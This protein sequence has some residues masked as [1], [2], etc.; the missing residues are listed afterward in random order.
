MRI[1]IG[2][3]AIALVLAGCTNTSPSN[4]SAIAKT[5]APMSGY[6]KVERKTLRD[7]RAVWDARKAAG[8]GDYVYTLSYSSV[9]GFGYT[10]EIEVS[11]G[12]VIRRKYDEF[13]VR[14]DEELLSYEEIGDA[15]GSHDAGPN[16]WTLDDLYDHCETV[17]AKTDPKMNDVTLT[18]TDDNLFSRCTIRPKNCMDDCTMG[19]SIDSLVFRD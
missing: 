15:V 6:N 2:F 18:V 1:L 14:E 8:S 13:S 7:S 3:S 19:V 16:V 12:R 4:P 5:S 10:A 11:D 17:L 9:F